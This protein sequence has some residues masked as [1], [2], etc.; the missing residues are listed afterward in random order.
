M[1]AIV[2]WHCLIHTVRA[3]PSPWIILLLFSTFYTE[4]FFYPLSLTHHKSNT[5]IYSISHLH[6]SFI[7]LNSLI[8]RLHADLIRIDNPLLL[9]SFVEEKKLQSQIFF[10]TFSML[11]TALGFNYRDEANL[12]TLLFRTTFVNR[13]V[14]IKILINNKF[15]NLIYMYIF[16]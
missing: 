11:E 3:N 8:F 5:Y 13:E 7:R 12:N 1:Y 6:R 4:K 9:A 15:I 10:F 2:W 16:I 14:N